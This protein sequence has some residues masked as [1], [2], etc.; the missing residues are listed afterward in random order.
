MSEGITIHIAEPYCC[1][2]FEWPYEAFDVYQWAKCPS[3]DN[4]VRFRVSAG[5]CP[6]PD[7]AMSIVHKM[8]R[9]DL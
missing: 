5:A 3:C 6:D 9:I 8:R 1:G 2:K 7:A 4:L